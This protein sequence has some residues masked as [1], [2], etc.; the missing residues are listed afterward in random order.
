M[1]VLYIAG[2]LFVGRP[3]GPL[4]TTFAAPKGGS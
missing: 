4:K 1:K 2:P 3:R